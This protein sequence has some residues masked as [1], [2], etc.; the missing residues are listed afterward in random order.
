MKRKHYNR[1][2]VIHEAFAERIEQ[3]LMEGFINTQLPKLEHPSDSID[4]LD[5][6]EIKGYIS[7]RER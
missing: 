2:W 1:C 5:D 3:L 7:Q 4:Y 6:E